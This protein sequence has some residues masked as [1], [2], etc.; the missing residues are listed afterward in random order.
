MT[1]ASRLEIFVEEPSAAAALRVLV[2]KIRDDLDF[3]IYEFQ[4]CRD[5]LGKLPE[6]FRGY[7]SWL[8]EDWRLVVLI[9]RDRKDC[10]KLKKEILDMGQKAGLRCTARRG[11][12]PPQVLVRIAV[13][14][15][16]SWF[17]G[18]I[19]ALGRAYPGVPKDLA[20]KAAFR[21][22]DA[23]KNTW[24]RLESVLQDAGHF[25]GGLEKIRC[26]REV[27]AHMN[28]AAN[29]SHSFRVFRDGLREL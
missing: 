13:E 29:S 24:E 6:R 11:A 28:P 14:E 5:L 16:E 9:D 12:P 8:P 23:I 27:A 7:A 26:A 15:L 22:P 20:R 1:R 2:P 4:G 19:P 21:D 25:R 10:L 3:G 18:D 17:F